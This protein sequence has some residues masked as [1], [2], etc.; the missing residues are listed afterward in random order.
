MS[1]IGGFGDYA[2]GGYGDMQECLTLEDV[3]M[4]LEAIL[5]YFDNN[6]TKLLIYIGRYMDQRPYFGANASQNK[7][8]DFQF[9]RG[10]FG[11]NFLTSVQAGALDTE[12][13]EKSEAEKKRE[14]ERAEQQLAEMQNIRRRA[15]IIGLQKKLVGD[16]G[17]RLSNVEKTALVV[18][19]A[20]KLAA[21][22]ED[23]EASIGLDELFNE[24]LP[25]EEK[26]WKYLPYNPIPNDEVDEALAEQLNIWEIDVNIK[27]LKGRN[28]KK[29][30][31][32]KKKNKIIYKVGKSKYIV[33]FIHGVL[34]CKQLNAPKDAATKGFQEL[35]PLLRKVAGMPAKEADDEKKKVTEKA[36]KKGIKIH[37]KS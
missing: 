35:I 25:E 9:W 19:E 3:D 26:N 11:Q 16:S 31:K 30:A 6:T 28:K 17:R 18:K 29:Q 12:G 27:R 32:S 33:R 37:G 20:I 8:G 21:Q 22:E 5:N 2:Y 7:Q 1:G 34:L 24:E 10:G 13:K 23:E 36:K 4:R 15:S 14:K